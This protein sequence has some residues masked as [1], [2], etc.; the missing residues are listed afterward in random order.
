MALLATKYLEP[1][2]PI[3]LM[4]LDVFV[5]L[6]NMLH[7]SYFEPSIEYLDL[8]CPYKWTRY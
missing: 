8:H 5:S 2:S 7:H 6:G 3:G 1:W 4:I